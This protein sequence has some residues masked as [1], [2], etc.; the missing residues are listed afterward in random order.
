MELLESETFFN[1][2]LSTVLIQILTTVYVIVQKN[3]YAIEVSE[4]RNVKRNK[5]DVTEVQ[6]V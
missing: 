2:E 6:I 4:F 3:V 5:W 1:Q